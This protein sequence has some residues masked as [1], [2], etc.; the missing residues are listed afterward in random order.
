[1]TKR[2][3]V[4]GAAG[5]IGSNLSHKLLDDG[6]LV[7]GLDNLNDYY[8]VDLKHDR[9]RTLT[10]REDFQFVKADLVDEQT[11]RSTIEAFD[12]HVIVHLAAQAGVR[13]SIDNPRAYVDS[14][15]SGFLS[16]LEAARSLRATSTSFEHLVYASSSSVYGKGTQAPYVVSARADTPVSLYAATKRANEL[17]AY[18]YAH[19]YGI[20]STGLRFFTVYGPAG[21]PDM[22]YYKF[23]DK[24][25]RGEAIEVYN[26]G[27]LRRDFTYI[28]DI[29]DGVERVMARAPQADENAP[30]KVYNI[31]NSSPETLLDFIDILEKNLLRTG[32]I[33]EPLNRVLLPM[34]PGDVY[35]TFAD[36][37]DM[38][39]DF[40]FRPTTSLADG[41]ERFVRWYADN[42]KVR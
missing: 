21:R 9:L 36:M 19:L 23:T 5:F 32:L 41:L 30:H 27:D 12:P 7:Y 8:R 28:D 16:I 14:N 35:E 25:V 29:V 17:M 38:E 2:A 22:A 10:S 39:V 13:Y 24:A 33:S 6:W 1:M 34:Q 31:G 42:E 37:S 40:G 4:T 3:F 11:V 15:L 18:T 20:P 26:N